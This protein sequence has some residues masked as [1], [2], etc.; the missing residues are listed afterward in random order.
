MTKTYKAFVV[1]L[2]EDIRE[3]DAESLITALKMLKGV[4]SVVPAETTNA[5][6]VA[7]TRVKMEIRGKLLEFARENLS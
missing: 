4:I 2:K 3:D 1:T 6:T 7:E 5:D